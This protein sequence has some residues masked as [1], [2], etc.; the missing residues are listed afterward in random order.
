MEKKKIKKLIAYT[1]LVLAEYF[2]AFLIALAYRQGFRKNIKLDFS[3][4][5]SPL[6]IGIFFVFIG[7]TSL[8][9]LLNYDK[10]FWFKNSIDAL[11]DGEKKQILGNLEQA[12]FQGNMEIDKNFT[13][14]EYSKLKDIE[15]DG[16]PVK[17]V[18]NGNKYHINLAR[19]A[20]TM[21]IGST[22]SGKT[23]SFINPTIQ[24]LSQS[25]T[26]PSMLITDPKGELLNLHAKSLKE[27]GYEV[28]VLDLRNP[29]NS[30][31]WNPLEKVYENYQ[32]MLNLETNVI[33]VDKEDFKDMVGKEVIVKRK[34]EDKEN[35][36][37][38]DA[39]TNDVTVEKESL[40][41]IKAD[42]DIKENVNCVA[43]Y[44]VKETAI[45]SYDVLHFL[46]PKD[47]EKKQTGFESPDDKKTN[48]D[49]DNEGFEGWLEAENLIESEFIAVAFETS[50]QAVQNN[51]NSANRETQDIYLD[52]QSSEQEKEETKENDTLNDNENE[53]SEVLNDD[54][55]SE[56]IVSSESLSGDVSSDNKELKESINSNINSDVSRENVGAKETSSDKIKRENGYFR[57]K[58]FDENGKRISALNR[59]VDTSKIGDGPWEFEGEVYFDIK[60]LVNA[61]KVERQKLFDEVYEDCNDF[62]SILCPVKNKKDP[63]WESG[64]KSFILAILLAM[65]EDSEDESLEMTKEKFNFYNLTKIAL[66]TQNDCKDLVKYFEGR[67]ELSKSTALSKQVLD[68]LDRTRGSY[69]STIFDKLNLFSDLSICSL[70]SAN[71]IEFEDMASKSVALFL[72]IP[73]EKETRHT[74][75][76]MVVLQAY[77][78][79]VAAANAHK[80]L[81]LPRPVYFI[82]DEF[83]N[84]PRINK[85][86]QMI[87]VGRS[88]NL[89]MFLVLQSYAQLANVYD[90]KVSEIIKS[91]CN[92]QIFIGSTDPKTLESFSKHCGNYSVATRNVSFNTS[93]TDNLSSSISV[94]ERP[95]IYPSELS[96]LNNPL[97]MGNAIV[98]VFGYNPIK[99]KYTPSFLVPMLDLSESEIKVEQSR[100]FDESRIFYDMK[101]RNEHYENEKNAR[102]AKDHI[103]REYEEREKDMNAA[104]LIQHADAAVVEL[105]SV[106]E[107]EK[108]SGYIAKRLIKK[109]IEVLET[110]IKK[111]KETGKD[112][113]IFEIDRARKYLERELDK[114][115]GGSIAA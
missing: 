11:S 59:E 26:K 2:I 32:K 107:R 43:S 96:K 36:K 90:E 39:K 51:I 35:I 79:L 76:A 58:F 3:V 57:K 77:K 40:E 108:L 44:K 75:A 50:K 55:S 56:N 8:I 87:T 78:D 21:V 64:A 53:K 45:K 94:K 88:R 91:N 71:E 5:L 4:F 106:E 112:N 65:L 6:V 25:K 31:K 49:E 30:V 97:D 38:E 80:D 104:L 109:A 62:V 68:S 63:L 19:P 46:E 74:L 13:K 86:E 15:I 82:L 12:R 22:G 14:V 85:L 18:V 102:F 61:I 113:L 81:S 37:K 101:K 42:E 99:S 69:L 70:T 17:A 114:S 95:L 34:N 54:F 41:N 7:L 9:I 60:D 98:T 115:I 66:N 27:K 33:S 23:T 1:C 16:V 110:A 52:N 29:Y 89:W 73:D 105:L 10:K 103:K 92:I 28:Q 72:Q 67:G 20:H 47:M 93:N 83:G 48:N 100:Y 24:I 111:A 84:L